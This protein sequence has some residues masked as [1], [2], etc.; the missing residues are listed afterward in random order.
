MYHCSFLKKQANFAIT[1][2]MPAANSGEKVL[3]EFFIRQ[4]QEPEHRKTC[5]VIH[6]PQ[7]GWRWRVDL[8]MFEPIHGM[9]RVVRLVPDKIATAGT[10]LEEGRAGLLRGNDGVEDSIY[11]IKQI[12]DLAFIFMGQSAEKAKGENELPDFNGVPLL[13]CGNEQVDQDELDLDLDESMDFYEVVA[14]FWQCCDDLMVIMRQQLP[15]QACAKRLLDMCD[16]ILVATET[17]CKFV[18]PAIVAAKRRCNPLDPPSD[19]ELLMHGVLTQDIK[20]SLTN[21]S[22][23]F[24]SRDYQIM[25]PNI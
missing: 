20:N 11:L 14:K 2:T 10:I 18:H 9:S 4:H 25:V 22:R 16:G 7:R 21:W 19:Q 17:F 1:N 8:S 15:H 5:C 12:K 23:Q 6:L 24:I 3:A 13:I